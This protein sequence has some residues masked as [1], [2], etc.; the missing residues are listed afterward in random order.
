MKAVITPYSSVNQISARKN[1]CANKT[2]RKYLQPAATIVI[3]I[4]V[5]VEELCRNAVATTPIIKPQIGLF[6][7][8]LL[9]AVP[10]AFPEKKK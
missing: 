7:K 9:K 2:R 1:Q 4:D 8:G 3:V 10:A 6:S 5:E